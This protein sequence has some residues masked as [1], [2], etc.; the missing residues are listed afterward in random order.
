MRERDSAI[1]CE[2]EPLNLL[3]IILAQVSIYFH[4]VG[5]LIL[6]RPPK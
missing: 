5:P 1:G 4:A 2:V 6:V 3:R